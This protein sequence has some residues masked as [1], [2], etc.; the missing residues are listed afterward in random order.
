MEAYKREFIE[1]LEEA[2][3][4]K[5]G[6]FVAKSGRN[7]PYFINAGMIKTGDQITKL[8]EFYAKAYFD[9]LGKKDAVLFGPA[10]KGIPLSISAAVALSKN[11]LNV[12]FFF[13]RKE[14]KDH[15]EGGTFV[16]YTPQ[17]GEEVVIIEDVITAGT[18]IRES[19]EMMKNLEGVKVI[20]TFI[21]VDRKEKGQ[22]EK[23]AMQ[24]IE[25]QF[26]FPI[27][28]IVDVYDIIEYLEEDPANEENV[29]R[30]KN[31]LAVNGAK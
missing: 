20:A 6:D 14:V 25:E 7:I 17:S 3:V 23:G 9:K 12:P 27:Y 28:S 8:G 31:Y 18:A 4:L 29:T 16:G 5:F 10:Y 26:G 19:M 11:G 30:I 15:G 24:E 2:G 1:F 13:N 22:G 21:M